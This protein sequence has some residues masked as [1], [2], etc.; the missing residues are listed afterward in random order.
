VDIPVERAKV[1][2]RRSLY[3]DLF[4]TDLS[5]IVEA[6]DA[7]WASRDQRTL[8]SQILD[9][10]KSINSLSTQE[11]ELLDDLAVRF[12]DQ[13]GELDEAMRQAERERLRLLERGR[14]GSGDGGR[15]DDGTSDDE[16]MQPEP[17]SDLQIPDVS[18]D[19]AGAYGWIR[20]DGEEGSE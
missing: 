10:Q 3:K 7:P 12:N 1:E 4:G 13:G 18:A 11:L 2:R 17:G 14:H 6:Y 16:D 15:D 8:A 9:G 5:V 20:G 19:I